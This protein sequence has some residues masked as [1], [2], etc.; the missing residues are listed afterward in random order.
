MKKTKEALLLLAGTGIIMLFLSITRIGCPIKAFT[1]ISC[2][3]CGMS[4]A[5]FALIHLK[6]KEAFYYHP[7]IFIMPALVPSFFFWEK[8]P[9]KKCKLI[10]GLFV[11][12]FLFVYIVRLINQHDDVVDINIENGWFFLV[13]Q[14]LLSLFSQNS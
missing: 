3:G 12:A 13:A 5:L 10:V 14:K 6:F 1:G 11:T 9:P 8:I 7:L 2:A 4:R